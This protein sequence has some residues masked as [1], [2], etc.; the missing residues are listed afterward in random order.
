VRFRVLDLRTPT[1]FRDGTGRH[2]QAVEADGPLM[3]RFASLT[4][5]FPTG[6]YAVDTASRN[7]VWQRGRRVRLARV[8]PGPGLVLA[9]AATVE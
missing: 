6:F 7:G 1:A 5:L 2:L 3:L 8:E 9:G 4:A